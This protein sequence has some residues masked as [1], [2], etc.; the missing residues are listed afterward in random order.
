[1]ALEGARHYGLTDE[2]LRTM[3]TVY[4]ADL[5]K[6]KLVVVTGA[7]SGFGFAIA[8]LFARLG[9]DLAILGRSQ[10][11]LARRSTPRLSISAITNVVRPTSPMSGASA[12]GWMR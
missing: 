1:M 6:G 4:R 11:R 7:G 10:E 9:A 8:T 3:P 2:E 12:V 5:F